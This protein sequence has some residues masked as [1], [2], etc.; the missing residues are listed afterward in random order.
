MKQVSLTEPV[1]IQQLFNGTSMRCVYSQ[2]AFD[3]KLLDTL[4]GGLEA[5]TGTFKESVY[6]LA[7]AQYQLQIEELGT[8]YVYDEEAFTEEIIE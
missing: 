6:T 3:E 8:D 1:E 7:I 4:M 5:C 2:G